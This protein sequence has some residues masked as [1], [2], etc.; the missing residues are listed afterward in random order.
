MAAEPTGVLDI[1]KPPHLT[2]HDVVNRVRK[3]TGIRRVGHAGTLDPLATGV[4]LV[5]VGSA[6]RIAEYLQAGRKIYSATLRLG[7]ETDTY[8]ADGNLLGAH[9]VPSFTAEQ[10]NAALASFRGDIMQTP[11]PYSA[12]KRGGRPLYDFAR[13]G[14]QIVVAP[15]PI[16]IFDLEIETWQH[17]DLTLRLTCS[18]G[19]YVRSLAHD[20]GQK[21]GCGAHIRALRRLASGSWR[22]E[23]AVTLDELAAQAPHWQPFL[24]GLAAALSMLPPL[25]LP[26]NLAYRFTLGQPIDIDAILPAQPDRADTTTIALPHLRVFDPSERFIGI[27]RLDPP[28]RL[29]PHKIFATPDS[30]IEHRSTDIDG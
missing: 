19:T 1:D 13:A 3:L 20:L 7:A 21:L 29:L 24:H 2:S 28:H 9:P 27:G 11:P 18:P 8:D 25:I 23:D 4:L 15:R 6:T 5:C 30:L 12:I 10:L 16:T 17:P 22:I 26:G 14:E